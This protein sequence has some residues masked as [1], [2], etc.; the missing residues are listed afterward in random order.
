M[1]SLIRWYISDL[2]SLVGSGLPETIPAFA[3]L[4]A[5]QLPLIPTWAGIHSMVMVKLTVEVRF[6]RDNI[7]ST[8]S[9]LDLD[10]SVSMACIMLRESVRITSLK[11]CC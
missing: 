9:G 1:A 2:A 10:L 6:S 3:A 5:A 11:Y 8:L 4:S 7:L